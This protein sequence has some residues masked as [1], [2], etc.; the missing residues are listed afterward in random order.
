M[1][2]LFTAVQHE[3]APKIPTANTSTSQNLSYAAASYYASRSQEGLFPFHV[4]FPTPLAFNFDNY[5]IPSP[6]TYPH[7][8]ESLNLK[9]NQNIYKPSNPFAPSSYEFGIGKVISSAE[10]SSQVQKVDAMK[11]DKENEVSSSEEIPSTILKSAQS[12]SDSATKL[13]F[14]TIRW[15][16]SIASFN[17]FSASEQKRLVMSSWPELFVLSASQWGFTIENEQTGYLK[18]FQNLIKHYN[19][20]KVDHFESACLKALIL[21]RGESFSDGI[22]QQRLQSLQNQSLCLLIEKCGSLRFGHLMLFI[23]QIRTVGN[24]DD[25]QENLLKMTSGENFI[26]KILEDF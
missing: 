8:T 20:I 25:L 26:T 21:F 17:Q 16:K 13:L 2:S 14:L 24:A 4:P 18:S 23:S 6:Y 5:Y 7:L 15:I 1:L 9:I 3:R 19:S 12:L 10:T 11:I 22:S